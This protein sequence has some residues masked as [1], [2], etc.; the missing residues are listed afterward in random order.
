MRQPAMILLAP[1]LAA[2]VASGWSAGASCAEDIVTQNLDKVTTSGM[3]T[4]A[5]WI[6]QS[7]FYRLQIV[8][9]RARFEETQSAIFAANKER[10]AANPAQKTAD[11]EQLGG[12]TS[13]FLG[14]AILNL[15]GLTVWY[16][17]GKRTLPVSAMSIE[18]PGRRLVQTST[19]DAPV[20][21]DNRVD[22]WLLKSDGMQME[23]YRYSCDAG[24]TAVDVLYEFPA[25]DNERPVAAAIRIDSEYYIEKLQ[26]LAAA[27]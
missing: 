1:C 25:S 5:L 9:D 7:D 3:V 8:L 6:R 4:T 10:H 19:P 13:Q 26:P 23:P 24:P 22:V 17:C 2:I 12:R 15:R 20:A 16:P 21:K 27:Q 11:L 18:S 14:D